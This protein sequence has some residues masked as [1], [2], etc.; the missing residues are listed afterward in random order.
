MLAAV[1]R[2]K[3]L[4]E[5]TNTT[6]GLMVA[7]LELFGRSYRKRPNVEQIIV[8]ITDGVPTKDVHKLDNEVAAVK[9]KGIRIIGLGVTSKVSSLENI[10]LNV[11]AYCC[12]VLCISYN[13]C[14]FQFWYETQLCT[15]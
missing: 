12:S 8:L 14:L 9:R 2:I 10:L 13:K 4:Q 15:V 3:Y 5:N 11:L 6:G 1:D 7:R